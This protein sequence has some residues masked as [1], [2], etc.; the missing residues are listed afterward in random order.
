MLEDRLIP[1]EEPTGIPSEAKGNDRLGSS[2]G[3]DR[4][5]MLDSFC[6]SKESTLSPVVWCRIKD[7]SKK[8]SAM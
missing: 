6:A 8:N 2:E 5:G 3:G 7:R 4:V 1:T